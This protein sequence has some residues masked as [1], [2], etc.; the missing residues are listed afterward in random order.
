MDLVRRCEYFLHNL[1]WERAREGRRASVSGKRVAGREEAMGEVE[2]GW[3][4]VG[5][6]GMNSLQR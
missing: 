2:V 1:V 3:G 5:I 6:C 4:L